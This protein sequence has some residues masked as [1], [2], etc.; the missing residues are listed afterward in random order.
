MGCGNIIVAHDNA[1][2]REVAGN[3]AF[4]FN[5]AGDIPGVVDA[6]AA[7]DDEK[8][9]RL[10]RDVQDRIRSHYDWERVADQY[11]ALLH[12]RHLDAFPAT[13]EGSRE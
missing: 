12:G 7:L 8:R 5:N 4:Y 2:N 10:S 1:F 13:G 11:Y 3:A 6:L 9:H